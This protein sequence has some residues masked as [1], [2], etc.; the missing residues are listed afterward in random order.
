MLTLI[1]ATFLQVS[2]GFLHIVINDTLKYNINLRSQPTGDIGVIIPSIL[3]PLLILVT[4][5]V[6]LFVVMLYLIMRR[7]RK[8]QLDKV[9]Y[10]PGRYTAPTHSSK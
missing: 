2:I 4:I 3:V 8:L 5:L 6:A 10:Q 9:W 7:T 1:Y